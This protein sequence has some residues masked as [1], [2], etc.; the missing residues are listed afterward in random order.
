MA[1]GVLTQE[2]DYQSS[3]AS[4][5]GSAGGIAGTFT[6]G[7]IGVPRL[8]SSVSE[9]EKT[10]GKPTDANFADWFSASDFLASSNALYVVRVLHSG[11]NDANATSTGLYDTERMI[12]SDTHFNVMQATN[13][14]DQEFYAR[15]PGELGNS[16]LVSMADQSNFS[17]WAYRN[18]FD[19]APTSTNY[20]KQVFTNAGSTQAPN[21]EVCIVVVDALGEITGAP[22]TVL[23]T[24]ANLS[25]CL[26]AKSDLGVNNYYVSTLNARSSYIYAGVPLGGTLVSNTNGDKAAWG[27]LAKAGV[28]FA[29]I[30]AQYTV[31]LS[32]GVTD[33]IGTASDYANAYTILCGLEDN[34]LNIII[35][36]AC[37]ADAHRLTVLQAIEAGCLKSEKR[38]AFCSPKISDF[39]HTTPAEIETA[40]LA[41]WEATTTKTNVM[42][43]DNNAKLVYDKY[44]SVY[45][46]IPCN[47]SV[48][49]AW[50]RTHANYGPW[51]SAAGYVRGNLLNVVKLMYSP[52]RLAMETFQKKG[53]NNIITDDGAVYLMGDKT[54]QQRESPFTYLGA[55]FLTISI[56]NLTRDSA[57][58]TLFESNDQRTRNNFVS[59]VT[60][61][62]ENIQTQGGL[63][64]F[65]VVCDG[66]N[67]DAYTISTGGFVCDIA[68]K[69]YQSIQWI[70]LKYS[71]L[72]A[73]E[74]F[75]EVLGN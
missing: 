10:F 13:A 11:S 41:T 44:N 30:N 50:A 74:S 38:V 51:K 60:P 4:P 64:A 42:S 71:V 1:F 45:R 31:T 49:G 53:I 55:R 58:Y 9:L 15:Y 46:I 68:F 18:L 21:D 28:T 66:S 25:K 59:G 27:T 34:R 43:M 62:L 29:P 33:S 61:L 17:T 56:K 24:F 63:Q 6:W 32:G 67:N 36:G 72:G 39:L 40:I 22:G 37:G 3:V 7:P 8:I 75:D 35:A 19:R 70:M 73:N 48:A 69:P 23:E 52:D 2:K 5:E 14:L 65:R 54:L 12:R 20:A 57:K 26:D 16:L 47:A